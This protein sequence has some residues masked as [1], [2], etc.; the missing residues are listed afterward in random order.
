V[1]PGV[2][3]A[4][5]IVQPWTVGRYGNSRSSGPLEGKTSWFRDV[6]L[7]WPRTHQLYM[8]VNL[9]P[10]SPGRNLNKSARPNQIPRLPR[11]VSC[12]ARPTNAKIAGA[13]DSE[14]RYV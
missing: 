3:A 4:M 13:Q 1:G 7:C 2:Y 10:V 12:G 14:D 11:R 9:P 6:N 5:D 8:P